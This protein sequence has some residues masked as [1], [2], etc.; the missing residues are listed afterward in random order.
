M[1]RIP[2]TVEDYKAGA[3]IGHVAI[4]MMMQ[5][6]DWADIEMISQH[7]GSMVKFIT[8]R[9]RMVEAAPELECSLLVY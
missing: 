5:L 7:H 1:K 2:M 4:T 8:A 9:V 6:D 3:F